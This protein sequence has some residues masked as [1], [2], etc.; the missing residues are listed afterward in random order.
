MNMKKTFTLLT[1]LLSIFMFANAQT[2]GKKLVFSIEGGEA[3][4]DGAVINVE[5]PA[6]LEGDSVSLDK[7]LLLTNNSNVNLGAT[8]KMRV[9]NITG[10]EVILA[11]LNFEGSATAV[12][13]FDSG[14]GYN[15]SQRDTEEVFSAGFSGLKTQSA[16]VVVE[17]YASKIND[18]GTY[19]EKELQQTITL[20]F[21]KQT[22]K[23]SLVFVDKQ[24]NVIEDG[25]TIYLDD[26]VNDQ[27][28]LG[29]KKINS[30][31][32]IRNIGTENLNAML[33]AEVA[34]LKDRANFQVCYPEECNYLEKTGDKVST[35]SKA[36]VADASGKT[37]IDTEFYFSTSKPSVGILN[38]Q[39][40]TAKQS[41]GEY[42]KDQAQAKVKLVFNSKA[43]GVELLSANVAERYNVFNAQG[44][45]IVGNATKIEGLKQGVYVVQTLKNNKVVDTKKYIV[46]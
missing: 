42:V 21:N 4:A 26:A 18:D 37:S 3:I 45:L 46:K 9:T 8:I 10:G 32:S 15:I 40:F 41:G 13:D 43:T 7:A 34:E 14:E 20:V 23:N 33:E 17:L 36:I 30:G 5:A 44:M 29:W 22:Q 24:G 19:G 35:P 27:I 31:L 16:T 1:M 39:I 28:R 6:D 25:A 2:A 38:M 12:G 11:A